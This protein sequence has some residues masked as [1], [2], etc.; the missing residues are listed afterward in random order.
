MNNG[1]VR[2]AMVPVSRRVRAYFGPFDHS[3]NQ[4]AVF[5]PG[6]HGAFSLDAPPA[7]WIDLGDIEKFQVSSGTEIQTLQSG[8]KGAPAGQFRRWLD[9]RV[10][11][12]FRCWGKLQMA[13]AGGSQHMNVLQTDADASA[14]PSGGIPVAAVAVLDGSSAGEIVLGAGAVDDFAIGDILAVDLDYGQQTG[15]VGSG[16]AAAYV[17]D[18]ADVQRDRDYVR[19]VTYN[20][21]RV[22][23]KTATSLLLAQPLLGGTPASGASAQKV[24]AFVDREGGSFFQDWSALF[25]HEDESGGRI[26]LYYPHLSPTR[27]ASSRFEPQQRAAI[28]EPLAAIRLHA[29]FLALPY[30]DQN[31]S[32]IA[33]CYRSYFPAE[34]SAL[35]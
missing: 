18:P 21:G 29:C 22:A 1:P 9:A 2:A 10:E 33:V 28:Q 13:L 17:K 15:W 5:D 14:R 8:S 19:R 20:V 25:V 24:A 3:M 7:P 31:D 32:E 35:Y 12:D 4:A 6:K 26:C 34:M 16:I 30:T 27:T 23:A 11:F